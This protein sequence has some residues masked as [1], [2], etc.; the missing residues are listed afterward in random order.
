MERL[1]TLYL[2]LCVLVQTHFVCMR[3]SIRNQVGLTTMH[4]A[5]RA[6]TSNQTRPATKEPTA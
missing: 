1:W 4:S 3:R 6:I 5:L 2:A